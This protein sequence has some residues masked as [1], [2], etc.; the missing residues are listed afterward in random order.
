[1][2]SHLPAGAGADC[3][4]VD[5][6][7]IEP[8]T[9][10]SPSCRSCMYCSQ[11]SPLWLSLSHHWIRYRS[12][13]RGKSTPIHQR[14]GSSWDQNPCTIWMPSCVYV[15][16]LESI[17]SIY[18]KFH[19]I[20]STM[21]KVSL[22]IWEICLCYCLCLK[23]SMLLIIIIMAES[24]SKAWTLWLIISCLVAAIIFTVTL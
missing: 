1:M 23:N 22:G 15:Q 3:I 21:L 9:D 13:Y 5:V 16:Q 4:T 2:S 20:L 11:S 10:F 24:Y 7:N 8:C 14:Y 6:F 18:F 17:K 12:R 19:N